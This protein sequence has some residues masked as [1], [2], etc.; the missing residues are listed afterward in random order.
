MTYFLKLVKL[1]ENMTEKLFNK[2]S[3]NFSG[4]ESGLRPF[5]KVEVSYCLKISIASYFKILDFLK[6]NIKGTPNYQHI[7]ILFTSQQSRYKVIRSNLLLTF[8]YIHKLQFISDKLRSSSSSHGQLR[9]LV[10]LFS[11]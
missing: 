3:K 6:P 4:L 8:L 7:L 9:G 5:K 1:I 11:Y 2:I 10:F